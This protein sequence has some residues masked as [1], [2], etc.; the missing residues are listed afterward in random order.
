MK[1]LW[2][3][4]LVLPD[5]SGEFGLRKYYVGGWMTSMLHRLEEKKEVDVAVC[6]PIIDPHRARDGVCKGHR[7]YSFPFLLQ[8]YSDSVK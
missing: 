4:N 7:Y 2:L 1:V 3:C 8:E 5:F 6:C